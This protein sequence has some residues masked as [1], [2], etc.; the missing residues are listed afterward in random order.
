MSGILIAAFAGL[1]MAGACA[2]ASLPCE[3]P[4]P[5]M[6]MSMPCEQAITSCDLPSFNAPVASALDFSITPVLLTTLPA[7]VVATN[8]VRVP[9]VSWQATHPPS[10]PIYLTHLALLN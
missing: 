5:T 1:W 2:A 9:P 4:C 6:E 3:S 10:T 7:D 8:V